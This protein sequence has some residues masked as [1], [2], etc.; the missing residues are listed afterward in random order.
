[1]TRTPHGNGQKRYLWA[2]LKDAENN[3]END[4]VCWKGLFWSD[5][6][7]AYDLRKK[8]EACDPKNTTP[9]VKHD[10]GNIMLWGCL[11]VSRTG[12]LVKVGEIITE[13]CDD[14]E[15]KPQVVWVVALSS[16]VFQYNNDPKNIWLQVKTI[17]SEGT[18][19][20]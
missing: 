13:R 1:M 8:G 17:K 5:E 3:L 16:S 15:Q 19:D 18:S 10:N 14:F 9:V 4:Y 7:F 20:I 12:N 11:S 6:L 2:K